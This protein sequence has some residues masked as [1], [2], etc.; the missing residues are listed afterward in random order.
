[1]FSTVFDDF[2]DVLFDD[3]RDV[4][5]FFFRKM[6]GLAV[7]EHHDIGILL[8]VSGFSQ[9]GQLGTAV[10]ARCFRRANVIEL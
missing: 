10:G 6:C 3:F 1:M 8:Q 4:F 9:I 5:L 7:D 2:L